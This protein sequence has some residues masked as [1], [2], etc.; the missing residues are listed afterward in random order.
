MTPPRGSRLILV[1]HS[2][3]EIIPDLPAR[4]WRLSEEGRGRCPPLAR[5]LARYAPAR[6]ISSVEPK[7]METAGIVAR[8]LGVA[9]RAEGGLHEQERLG[10]GWLDRAAL[11]AGVRALFG[12]PADLVF[13]DETADAAHARFSAA[14]D[15]VLSSTQGE[16]AAIVAHG[17]VISLYVSRA[18]GLDPFELWRSL[19]LPSYVVLAMPDRALVELCARV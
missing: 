12:R 1:K 16:T 11:E 10:V 4:E 5:A 7:A 6:V 17:T 15:A 14:V 13:G 19:E 3:P 9:A 18:C 8:E 2:L